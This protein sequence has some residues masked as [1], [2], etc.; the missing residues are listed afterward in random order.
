MIWGLAG[1]DILGHLDQVIAAIIYIDRD[2]AR[3][4]AGVRRRFGRGDDPAQQVILRPGNI[5]QRIGDDGPVAIPI[6]TVARDVAVLILNR[7]DQA[8]GVVGV[9]RRPTELIDYSFEVVV[10]VVA[11]SIFLLHWL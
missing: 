9:D 7:R 3:R 8:L 4:Q 10:G 1:Q 5:P 11:L 6:V 2:L